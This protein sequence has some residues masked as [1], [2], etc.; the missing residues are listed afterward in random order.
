MKNVRLFFCCLA[1]LCSS[2]TTVADDF[3]ISLNSNTSKS[4]I[5]LLN[6]NHPLSYFTTLI[7]KQL[8]PPNI[9]DTL[10]VI[11]VSNTGQ[12]LLTRF[13]LNPLIIRAES[14]NPTTGLIESAKRIT[15]RTA[16]LFIDNAPTNTKAFIIYKPD[17]ANN[18]WQWS[19][20][21][22]YPAQHT[23][24]MGESNQSSVTRFIDNGP[25]NNRVDVVFVAEGYTSNE[26]SRFKKDLKP[27]TAGFF[28][29]SPMDNYQRSFN[30]WAV[31][32]ISAESGAGYTYPKNTQF[33]SY[34]NCYNIARLLCVDTQRVK[35]YVS[36]RL[37]SE[38]RDLIIV[39]VNSTQYGGSGG[40]VATMSLHSSAV[41]LAL[42]ESGHTF[43]LLADEYNY[44]SCYAG[45]TSEANVTYYS[46]GRKWSHWIGVDKAVDVFEGAKYCQRGMYR[47]TTNSL[48]RSL[49]QPFQSVNSEQLIRR[50]YDYVSPID[51][52]TPENSNVKLYRNQKQTFSVNLL[53]PHN[54]TVE[55]RWQLN[56]QEVGSSTQL[57]LAAN[58]Y[59]P[60]DYTLTVQVQDATSQVIKDTDGKL[61]DSVNW[62]ITIYPY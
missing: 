47:P 2:S 18:K 28:D 15:Q 32:S 10:A 36:E 6:T 23:S 53:Q 17:Y 38:A 35:N 7:E 48:M 40:S 30:V 59:N 24:F 3:I 41:D 54:P 12:P 42:H 43:G 57:T 21:G 56:G 11:A 33:R 8:Q 20:L 1:V 39:V 16:S 46:S 25:S 9:K 45:P 52:T 29:E 61:K 14:F 37:P 31:E 60:G 50:V 19:P 58:N 49:G 5:A 34:F 55:A 13:V 27:I 44:G 22:Q 4:T 51:S 26:I 62:S